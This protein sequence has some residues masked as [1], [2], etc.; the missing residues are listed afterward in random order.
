MASLECPAMEG[1]IMKQV[2][3]RGHRIIWAPMLEKY[4]IYG[5]VVPHT[6]DVV[7]TLTAAVRYLDKLHG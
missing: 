1:G 2:L 6:L 7:P 4:L 3:Y 5:A